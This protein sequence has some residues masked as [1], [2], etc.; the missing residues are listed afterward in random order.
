ML[1]VAVGADPCGLL[2]V[3]LGGWPWALLSLSFSWSIEDGV[4]PCCLPQT[5]TV[6]GCVQLCLSAFSWMNLPWTCLLC[7]GF[8]QDC[9]KVLPL[10]SWWGLVEVLLHCSV[11]VESVFSHGVD[12]RALLFYTT[13]GRCLCG[14][15]HVEGDGAYFCLN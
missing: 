14:L 12:V 10:G 4:S 9:M 13:V 3:G 11:V 15:S 1:R 6:C 7:N 2:P 8:V 5:M